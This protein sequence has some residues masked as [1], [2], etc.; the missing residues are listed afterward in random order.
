MPVDAHGRRADIIMD[1]LSAV[2]RMNVSCVYEQYINCARDHVER[3]VCA[4]MAE[5]SEASIAAAWEKVR[6][7]YSLVSPRM[8]EALDNPAYT[9]TPVEHLQTIVD[10]GIYLYMQSISGRG[11]G[12]ALGV[13][14]VVVVGL[15]TYFSHRFVER[16]RATVQ[17]TSE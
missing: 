4:W 7:F 15:G 10:D 16:S 12:A 11:P 2:K 5:G 6:H 3:E 1:G 17:S 13:L 14:A 8:V 9:M